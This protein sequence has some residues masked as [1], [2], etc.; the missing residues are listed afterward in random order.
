MWIKAKEFNAGGGGIVG[1]GTYLDARGE[2]KRPGEVD[3]LI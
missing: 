3:R 2:Y 1:Y